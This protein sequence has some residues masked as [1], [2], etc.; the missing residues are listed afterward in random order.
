[1][2]FATGTPVPSSFRQTLRNMANTIVEF[3]RKN[4]ITRFQRG[5]LLLNGNHSGNHPHGSED[6]YY[7][8]DSDSSTSSIIEISARGRSNNVNFVNR[9]RLTSDSS[10]AHV[11]LP[12]RERTVRGEDT[13][14]DS[15][16]RS[17]LNV[18]IS[19]IESLLDCERK[20]TM[21]LRLRE[22][23]GGGTKDCEFSRETS[24]PKNSIF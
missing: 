9:N 10:S 2:L 20:E 17:F 11:S 18:F 16:I 3:D 14:E 1:M 12:Q 24:Y 22:E 15:T 5:S 7:D 4:R 13:E 21:K 6:Y 19:F 8:S 23:G